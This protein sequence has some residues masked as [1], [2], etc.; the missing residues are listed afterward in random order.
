M[1]KKRLVWGALGLMLACVAALPAARAA[2][3]PN[4]V[5]L[6]GDDHGWEETGY[7]G[8]AYLQTPVLDTMAASGLRLDRFYAGHPSCSP[9]RGS[10]LTGRHPVR[11]GTFA[12]NW[13]MRPEEI[14]IAHVLREAGYATGHFG[15]WHVGAVKAG[16]P[17]NPGAMG[18]DEW[19]SHDN[20][21]ELHPTLSRNGGTARAVRGRELGR[22]RRRGHPVH[23]E[24][25]GGRQ[26]VPRRRLVRVAA[27]A[28]QRARGG[29]RPL[30]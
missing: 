10:V 25:H 12:P 5:L 18:F 16:S 28:L 20:F 29:P 17:L 7:N 14:T 2:D 27:R 24:V 26:A 19:L 9:T 22:R 3:R 15:K 23:R 13:S 1:R 21:F 11:Y 8:H 30:R 6:M 4:V